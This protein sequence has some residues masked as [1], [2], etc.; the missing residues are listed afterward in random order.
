MSDAL[1]RLRDARVVAVLR[2]SSGELV[3]PA[4]D[5]LVAGGIGA[6]ELTFTTP[7]VAAELEAARGRHPQLLLGAGTIR[8]AEEA[9]VAAEAGAEFLVMPHMDRRLL[10]AC[11]TTGLPSMPGVFTASELASALDAGTAVVKLFPAG[12]V[13]PAHMRALLGPFPG[14]PIVPT[15]GIGLDDV[16]TWLRAGAL[17]VGVGGALC[18]TELIDAGRFDELAERARSFSGVVA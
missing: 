1:A 10:A 14:V 5:A 18:S 12:T 13:G 9:S 17:A 7:G 16:S 11:L 8:R 15:G 2:V 4:V 3:E 6:V